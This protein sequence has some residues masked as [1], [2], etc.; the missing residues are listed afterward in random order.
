MSNVTDFPT[1]RERAG[2]SMLEDMDNL[3][4]CLMGAML[5]LKHSENV[6]DEDRQ[7]EMDL[8]VPLFLKYVTLRSERFPTADEEDLEGEEQ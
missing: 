7:E 6:A 1:P 8:L 4:D 5:G 2:V 3:L